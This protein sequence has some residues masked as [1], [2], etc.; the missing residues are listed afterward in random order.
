MLGLRDHDAAAAE[1]WLS[2]THA[3]EAAARPARRHPVAAALAVT[4]VAYVV[5]TAA[6]TAIGLL[7]THPLAGS[8]GTWDR[9]VCEFFARHRSG[10]L[11]DVTKR[12]TSGV[13][14]LVRSRHAD[15]P[16]LIVAG[17]AIVV[18]GRRGRWREGAVLAIAFALEATV[19]ASVKV[20]VGRP[21]PPVFDLSAAPSNTSFPSGHT[22]AATVL[23]VGIALIVFC[24]TRSRIAR[25]VS[26]VGATGVV[27]MVAFARVYRGLHFLTDVSVGAL[28]GLG[29]LAAAVVAVRAASRRTGPAPA[30]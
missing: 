19:F 1:R 26:V 23:F 4:V 6:V 30:G 7:I 12:A 25:A 10:L 29:C 15:L 16:A 2:P 3:P 13:G 20:L 18:L 9:H 14:S 8:L 21:R 27:S 17:A 22:A 5:L 11:N 24:S 28:L